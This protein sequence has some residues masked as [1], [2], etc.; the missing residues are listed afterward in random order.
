MVDL[1]QRLHG[2]AQ[3]VYKFGCSFIHLSDFHN[4]SNTNP[5]DKLPHEEQRNIIDHMRYYHGGPRSDSP[6]MDE[7]S[8]YFPSVLDKISGNLE[9]YLCDLEEGKSIEIEEV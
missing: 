4:Y 7:L 3:S 1:A 8:K 2:W 5:L 6:D 9:S